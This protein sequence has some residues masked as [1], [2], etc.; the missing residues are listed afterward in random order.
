MREAVFENKDSKQDAKK[1]RSFLWNLCTAAGFIGGA[2]LLLAGLLLS[3]ASYFDQ[4]SFYGLDAVMIGASFVLL[5]LGAHFLDL[6]D[7]E[8]KRKKKEKL[9]L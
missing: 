2:L 4:I 3:A 9:H 5:M 1:D 8:E 7:K 6:A